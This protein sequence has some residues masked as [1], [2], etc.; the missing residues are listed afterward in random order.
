MLRY[1]LHTHSTAS[2]GALSPL[3]LVERARERGV[4]V[5]ALTDHDTVAGVQSLQ[6]EMGEM[7]LVNGAELTCLWGS[8]MV[9]IVG[10][11]LDI[12]C[13]RLLRYLDGIDLLRQQRAEQ[14]A[15]RLM[16]KGLPDLLPEAKANAA[17]GVIGRPHFAAAMVMKGLVKTEQQ[18]F[19]QYL[20]SGKV[21]D[22]KMQWPDMSEAIS[23]ISQAGGLAVLAHPTKYRF[24]FTKIRELLVQFKADGGHGM[25]VSYTGISP[26]HQLELIKLANK[27]EL[28]VSAGS[29]FHSPAQHWTDVGRF[30]PVK[31][32]VEHIISHLL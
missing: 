6:G 10:L 4:E 12:G 8:R 28:L 20:G 1:D 7:T 2:D 25:E 26:S 23:M 21:G 18:A 31:Q 14:V 32:P 15:V 9:H 29:D 3:A 30:M 19:T 22:V 11:R 24:T 16:K 13:D 27:H 17:D 5:L